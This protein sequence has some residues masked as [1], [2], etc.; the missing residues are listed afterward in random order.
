[1]RQRDIDSAI[2]AGVARAAERTR[3]HQ[4]V[5]IVSKTTTGYVAKVNGQEMEF[6]SSWE[7]AAMEPGATALLTNVDGVHEITRPAAYGGGL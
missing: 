6:G 3:A 7:G 1:M 4:R 5:Q 2:N